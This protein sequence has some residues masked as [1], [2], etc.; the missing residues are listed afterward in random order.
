[1]LNKVLCEVGDLGFFLRCKT[2]KKTSL[3]KCSIILFASIGYK[4][5]PRAGKLYGFILMV[6][7]MLARYLEAGKWNQG[8]FHFSD[9]STFGLRVFGYT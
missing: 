8:S 3:F 6:T 4:G 5:S 9:V 7:V 2:V 1:M